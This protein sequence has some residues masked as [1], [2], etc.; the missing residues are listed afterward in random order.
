MSG[1]HALQLSVKLS[2]LERRIKGAE[3]V[4]FEKLPTE[5][6]MATRKLIEYAKPNQLLEEM[7]NTELPTK[8]V[9]TES[10]APEHTQDAPTDDFKASFREVLRLAKSGQQSWWTDKL[11]EST[12]AH[13][14]CLDE[15]YRQNYLDEKTD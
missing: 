11:K 4:K 7:V 12:D 14:E 13:I 3:L 2:E 1:I 8:F 6:D 9:Q 15:Y 10:D 5:Q